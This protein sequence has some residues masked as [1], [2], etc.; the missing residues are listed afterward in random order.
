T[1]AIE[2]PKE[3]AHHDIHAKTVNTAFTVE[4]DLYIATRGSEKQL[5]VNSDGCNG[6]VN[7]QSVHREEYGI[8]KGTFWDPNGEKLAF[9]RM[10][11]SMVTE[12]QLEDITTRPS[13]F[14]AIRYPM[15]GQ[16]SH[17]VTIGIFDLQS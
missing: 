9:Y 2:L 11:E 17:H 5:R 7:G 16:P 14:E 4:D 13:T 6:I 15:A 3:A 10:D 12:Y 8:H 1:K